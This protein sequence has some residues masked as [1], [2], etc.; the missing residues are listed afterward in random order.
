MNSRRLTMRA[1][2]RSFLAP[3]VI[4]A[5]SMAAAADAQERSTYVL[6]STNNAQGNAVAVF[7]LNDGQKP[8]LSLAY[9]LR[10][11]GKGGASNNAGIVQFKDDYGAVANYGSNTVS[12]LVRR[13]DA[14]SMS[15]TIHLASDCKQPDSVALKHDHLFVVGANCAESYTWPEAYPD[16]TPVSLE[17]NSAA[18]IAVGRTW[19][20]VTLVSGSVLQLPLT[21][22]DGALNGTSK[23]IELPEDA[24]NT[25]LGEAFWGDLLGFNPAHSPDSLALINANAE[26]TPILGPA[27]AF[28][29]NAPCWLAK[30]PLSVWYAGNSPGQAVSIFFTDGQGGSFYKSVP[31]PGVATDITVSRDQKWLAVIYT[32]TDG[33]HI[34]AFAID[35]HGDLKQMA[36]SPSIGAA[37]FSGVAFSE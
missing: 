15:K 13:G 18:Q 5:C 31:V 1:P 22:E 33:A 28:P 26:V 2:W 6:T 3:A 24:N 4:F 12:E 11:G 30:G 19:A 20:A 37:T 8:S 35:E 10:T 23:T 14:I 17:D 34:A 16:G 7:R 21:H 9:M 32:A 25:P 29:I 36:T 27:P